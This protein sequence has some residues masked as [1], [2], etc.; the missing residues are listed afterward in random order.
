MEKD[1]V[2]YS[3]VID[4][5]PIFYWQGIIFVTSLIEIAKVNPKCIHIH[6]IKSNAAFEEFL[7]KKGV[8]IIYIVPWGDKKYC[9]KLQQVENT[10]LQK[11]DYVFLCDADV[12]IL[13]DISTIISGD[14][15]VGK[16]V[17]FDNPDIKLLRLIFEYYQLS[18]P[19]ENKQTLNGHLTFDGNFNGG[20][21]GLPGKYIKIFGRR[22]KYWADKLIKSNYISQLLGNKNIHIDQISFCMT[23]HEL[24]Y[25][26][27]KLA[28]KFNCPTHINEANIL[29]NQLDMEPSVLHY[30]TELSSIG[31]LKNIGLDIVDASINKVNYALKKSNEME[32]LSAFVFS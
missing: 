32:C 6:L 12:A 16:V 29:L 11:A 17:D 15:V 27:K 22:W 1:N 24:Q 7:V 5:K 25:P 26:Y 18:F 20:M 19:L 9:N 14:E 28:L 3:C 13:N 2:L 8:N 4:N 10:M 30:H 31:L 21:Y 23:L